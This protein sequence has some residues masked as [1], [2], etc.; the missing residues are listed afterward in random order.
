[1]AAEEAREAIHRAAEEG[2]VE[3]VARMLDEDPQLLM[4][5]DLFGKAGRSGHVGVARLL[6]AR[7]T[8]IDA[9]DGAW[10]T[11]L[12]HAVGTGHEEMVQFLLTNGADPSTLR[13]GA[14]ALMRASANGRAGVVR[15]LLRSMGGRGLD[16]SSIRGCTAL[17]HACNHGSAEIVRVL[18]LAGAD[19]T[20]AS[21]LWGTPRQVA[22][23]QGHHHC[24][25]VIEVRSP[26]SLMPLFVRSGTLQC[27]S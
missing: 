15:L 17:W 21:E 13:L 23:E 19:H 10:L 12:H 16:M 24:V 9:L 2:D 5:R 1:M 27:T 22:Q 7:G 11:A 26:R 3:G 6:L 20:I 25:A 18:L 4:D 14:T 8:A